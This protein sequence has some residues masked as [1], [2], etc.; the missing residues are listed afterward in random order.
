MNDS[1]SSWR[2]LFRIWRRPAEDDVDLELQFHLEE[3]TAEL[4]GSGT[5]PELAAR[6]AVQEFGNVAGVRAGLVAIDTRIARRRS[7]RERW[8]W[9]G[10]DLRYVL[11]NLRRSP[12]FVV[13]VVLMLSFGLGANLAILSMLDELF[14]A[15]PPGI[16]KAATVRR[17]VEV[18]PPDPREPLR[19]NTQAVFAY[20]QFSAFRAALPG[21]TLAGYSTNSYKIG[22]AG[23]AADVE[24]ESVLGR[25]FEL[26]GVRPQLGRF[27]SADELRPETPQQLAVLG[28]ALWRS[29]YHGRTD[30]VGQII[31]LDDVAYTVIGVAPPRFHGAGI[32]GADVWTPMNS[33]AVPGGAAWY[34]GTQTFWIQAMLRLPA[35]LT[36]ARA[37]K[38]ASNAL[39]H[40]GIPWDRAATARLSPMTGNDN[41]RGNQSMTIATRL[42]GVALIVLLIA[43]A[44]IA[45]LLLAR[46][47]DRR[48]EIG[49]RVALGVSRVRLFTMLLAE[50]L[51]VA[52][53]G[54]AAGL[55]VAWRGA[56]ILRTILLP[57]LHWVDPTVNWR[58]VAAAAAIAVLTGLVAGLAPAWQLSRPQLTAWLK[59]SPR[60]P[61]A[62][63]A[64][65]R[66]LL[67]LTQTALSVVLLATAGMF[68]GSLLRIEHEP[69]GLDVDRL[70][71]VSVNPRNGFAGRRAEIERRLPAVAQ[72]LAA[73]PGVDRI[74]MA[75]DAP[76]RSIYFTKWYLPGA[77]TTLQ[78]ANGCPSAD[79]IGPGYFE[80]VGTH[81]IRGRPFAESDKLGEARAIIVSER[82]AQMFWPGRDPLT[83]CLRI[84]SLNAPCRPVVGVV[85]NVHVSAII[86]RPALKF[87]L[88]LADTG[89][90][91]PGAVMVRTK[92]AAARR[93]A[94]LIA[95]R[96]QP[97]FAGWAT[98]SARPMATRFDRELQPWRAGA[99]LFVVAGL[100]AFVVAIVGIYTTVS[101]SL[102]QRTREL[103]I[104][105]ALGAQTN[106][107]VS[108][109]LL[110]GLR[111]VVAGVALG[112]AVTAVAGKVVQSLLYHTTPRDPLVLGIA[113]VVLVLAAAL[114]SLVPARRALNVDPVIALR[115]E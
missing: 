36:D 19:N 28:D 10:Q 26:L 29:S 83:Q 79:H 35:E 25:Y 82:M 44:N 98:V 75:W 63:R 84:D 102:S 64:R 3:R 74:A 17:I 50:S 53:V 23:E 70:V 81:V 115:T 97:E 30:I 78:C 21:A 51:I 68:V 15:P 96:L 12:G 69:L 41:F 59:G 52:M 89:A 31:R 9:V 18:L 22:D 100:L 55:F 56:A 54:G 93:V 45:N 80:T 66:H 87:Y 32:N 105:V 42:A 104:R 60:D 4:V 47:I 2:R 58:L 91:A 7:L 33:M 103:G 111:T 71:S 27:F 14:L 38:I 76:M 48:H 95:Q 5:P 86:E 65:A 85:A 73:L 112:V 46:G 43:C 39:Q 88:P 107:I 77:D 99:T 11:R 114:A 113:S 20:P 37:A 94:A 57:D 8:E 110:D 13:M 49:I 67:L 101:F 106:D 109:I 61:A 40:D 62:G 24:V 34:L 16:A 1:P 108:L 90:W 92:P 72:E 6:K